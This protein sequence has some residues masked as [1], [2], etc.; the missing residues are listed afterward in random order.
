MDEIKKKEKW[1]CGVR[2]FCE[3]DTC[4]GAW[5]HLIFSGRKFKSIYTR[6]FLYH[7]VDFNKC[8]YCGTTKNLAFSW[9]EGG[10]CRKCTHQW[11]MD[12]PNA[13]HT[14]DVNI[15]LRSLNE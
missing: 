14:E 5:V 11:D 15:L 9:M 4:L 7:E 13:L 2:A 8:S 12:H 6:P 1:H 3:H 10:I